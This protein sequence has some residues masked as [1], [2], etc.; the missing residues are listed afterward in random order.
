MKKLIAID[1]GNVVSAYC[2]LSSAESGPPELTDFAILENDKLL[3]TLTA[4]S[5]RDVVIEQITSYGQ[6]VGQTVFD[7]C[8]AVGRMIERCHLHRHAVHKMPR[9]KVKLWL[10]G[11]PNGSDADVSNAVA[12]RY[13]GFD[14]GGKRAAKGVK[15][16][17]GPLYGVSKDVWQALALGVTWLEVNA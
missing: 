14:G 17:P 11:R 15:A 7:T 12:E 6:T 2:C 10:L 1:P 5:P 16:A 9:R 13:V 4:Y 8:E 3:T